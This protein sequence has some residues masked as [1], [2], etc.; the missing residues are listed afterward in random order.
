MPSADRF[1]P[2]WMPFTS[3]RDMIDFPPLVIRKASGIYLEDEGGNRYIDAVGSWWVSLFG[4]RHPRIIEAVKEQADRLE[5]VMMAGCISDTT[6]RLSEH[7]SRLLPPGLD[8]IFYSDNGSTAVEVSLKMALQYHIQTGNPQRREFIALGGGYHGDTLGAMTVGDIAQYHSM[9]HDSFK[10]AHF[11]DPPYCFRC[12]CGKDT[13][14][15]AAE[16]MDSLGAL[17]DKMG[18]VTAAM[19]FEPMVQGANGMRI[20]PVKVLQRIFDICRSHGILT[21]ADEVAMGFGR[22]G[23]MFAFE[24]AS[25]V[26]DMM[27]CSKGI[28]GGTLPL[29]ITAVN[30][31]IFEA[32]KGDAFSGR[33]F[34]HGH[35]FTGNPLACAAGCAAMELLAEYDIP[36]SLTAF[37]NRL[38]RRLSE[39][40][41]YDNVGDVRT[42]GSVGAIELVDN[43]ATRKPPQSRKRLAF[44]IC[45]NALKRGLLLRPLGNVIYF[46]LPYITTEAQLDTIIGL[47]HESFAEEIDAYRSRA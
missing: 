9:F 34:E 10:K 29:A 17:L 36:R 41:V 33:T 39:F 1:D 11:T 20:Y 25:A 21:I 4:H 14:T 40:Y 8:K 24:H 16:C 19:I 35:T 45:R 28:T 13:T 38:A 47:T 27:C 6:I 7:L 46:M 15:C 37:N 44:A 43:R 42:L 12:P 30:K 18:D 5:H 22:T 31:T 3:Y 32:F 26:P 2:I 23:T